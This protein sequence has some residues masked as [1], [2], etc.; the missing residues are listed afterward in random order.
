MF[1]NAIDAIALGSFLAL[2][3]REFQWDRQTAVRYALG[4]IAAGA[5]V[6]CACI[7]LGIEL[8]N[9]LEFVREHTSYDIELICGHIRRMNALLGLMVPEI[10]TPLEML[11]GS[12]EPKSE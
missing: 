10:V 5:A 7:P 11:G 6:F 12:N 8:G 3:I 9:V 1:W 4:T 2:A